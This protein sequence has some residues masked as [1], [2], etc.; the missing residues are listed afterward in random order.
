MTLT[1]Q[2]TLQFLIDNICA[3]F[4]VDSLLRTARACLAAGPCTFRDISAA[5]MKKDPSLDQGC[6]DGLAEGVADA[7]A[8]CG[9][10]RVA[11]G[12]VY[13]ASGF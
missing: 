9:E 13:P 8:D 1:T 10:A 5:I 6:A 11:D 7:L 3:D 2:K 12:T 4:T